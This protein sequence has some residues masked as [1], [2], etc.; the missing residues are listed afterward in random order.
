MF[1]RG[2]VYSPIRWM[3]PQIFNFLVN[4]FKKKNDNESYS[5]YEIR[6]WGY[7]H[8]VTGMEN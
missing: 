6:V 1:F 2:F 8:E 5:T 7:Y 3:I 4:L